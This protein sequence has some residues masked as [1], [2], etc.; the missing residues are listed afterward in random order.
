MPN[1]AKK[2]ERTVVEHFYRVIKPLTKLSK[3][4]IITFGTISPIPRFDESDVKDLCEEAKKIVKSQGPLLRLKPPCYVIGDVHGDIHDLLRILSEIGDLTKA[5]IIFLGDYIDRGGFSIEIVITLFTLICKF[6]DNIILLRGN[7]EFPNVYNCVSLQEEVNQLYQNNS[8]FGI[9]HS[10]FSWLPLAALV[11]DT[12]L[13]LHG[14]IGPD[15]TKISDIENIQYPIL[16]YDDNKIVTDILWSDPCKTTKNYIESSRGRGSFFGVTAISNFLKENNLKMVI[17]GHQCVAKGVEKFDEMVYTVFST[18]FYNDE[19]NFGAFIEID[20]SLKIQDHIL[21]PMKPIRRAIASYAQ[22][23]SRKGNARKCLIC[24]KS[25]NAAPS[26][27]SSF[28][29]S[30]PTSLSIGNASL[31]ANHCNVNKRMSLILV[32]QIV[33]PKIPDLETEVIPTVSAQ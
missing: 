7:H 32:P 4:K 2:E 8:L 14:G 18:S 13:C 33:K 17:R 19:E 23:P 25:L 5:K 21:Q 29:L 9:I 16:D 20:E 28:L 31:T 10:V 11:S 24:P 1:Q 6:P 3:Q 26:S 12:Y 15:F 27:L 30:S 22:V